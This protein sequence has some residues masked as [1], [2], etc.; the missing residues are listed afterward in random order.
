LQPGREVTL[1]VNAIT[2]PSANVPATAGANQIN[3]TVIGTGPGGQLILKAG[4]TTLFVR[5]SVDLPVG[6]NLLITVAPA[7][8]ST[9]AL[10]PIMNTQ[11]VSPLQQALMALGQIDPEI[12]QQVMNTVVPQPGANMPAALL[13]FMSAMKQGDMRNSDGQLQILNF[14]VHNSSHKSSAQDDGKDDAGKAVSG[15]GAS[16]VRFLIDMR[17]TRLGAI[18]LDG[19]VQTRKFD[20]MVRSETPLPFDLP[21]MLREGYLSRLDALG[22]SGSLN[23]QI[24]RQHWLVMQRKPRS[25]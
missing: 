20:M 21:K 19:L 12:A 7:R 14:Y 2:P 1:Q 24:G 23:F 18:Q 6:T 8:L 13:F 5:Q 9:P 10:L 4:D 17:L 15:P 3:A 25:P 16:Q 11:E 22:Y